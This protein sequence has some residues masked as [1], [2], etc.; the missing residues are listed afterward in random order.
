[1]EADWRKHSADIVGQDVKVMRRINNRPVAVEA[2]ITRCGTVVGP[3]MT[4][5]TGYPELTPY[6][7]GWTAGG[8]RKPSSRSREPMSPT[9]SSPN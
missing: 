2:V 9:S 7:G 6:R 1:M 4:E 3:L 5:L 8:D